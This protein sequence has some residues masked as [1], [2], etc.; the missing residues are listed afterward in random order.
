MNRI[1]GKNREVVIDISDT[2]KCLF[3][4]EYIFLNRERDKSSN[5][6]LSIIYFLVNFPES[7]KIV[8]GNKMK[9]NDEE[10]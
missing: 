4:D 6:Q 8:F 10:V 7:I 9:T 3:D 1:I 2:T 5:K